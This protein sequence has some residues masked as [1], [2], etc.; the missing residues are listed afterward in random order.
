MESLWLA[1]DQNGNLILGMQVLA[2]RATTIGPP[3]GSFAFYYG[4]RQH[5]AKLPETAYEPTTQLE[6]GVRISSHNDRIL[7]FIY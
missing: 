3:T 7:P 6:V 4:A 2:V 1:V 5:F